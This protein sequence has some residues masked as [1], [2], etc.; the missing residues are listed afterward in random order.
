MNIIN[1][2]FMKFL[3]LKVAKL[4]NCLLTFSHACLNVKGNIGHITYD[5]VGHEYDSS[6]SKDITRVLSGAN[7]G[8]TFFIL[9]VMLE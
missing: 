8:I 2:S 3:I 5:N 1:Y 7:E 6:L 9:A 4:F